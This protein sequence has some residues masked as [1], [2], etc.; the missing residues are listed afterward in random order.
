MVAPEGVQVLGLAHW[1]F[2][3]HLQAVGRHTVKGAHQ[4]V[5][6]GEDTQMLFHVLQLLL[7]EH[8]RSH[9]PILNPLIAENGWGEV[10]V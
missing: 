5:K 2:G 10:A 3:L 1:E 9:I 4:A 7:G 6:P 8:A